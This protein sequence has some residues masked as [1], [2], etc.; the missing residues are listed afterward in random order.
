MEQTKLPLT[1]RGEWWTCKF[2]GTVSNDGS[3]CY[4][5]GRSRVWA[6]RLGPDLIPSSDNI[7]NPRV[8][9]VAGLNGRKEIVRA[10]RFYR[11]RRWLTKYQR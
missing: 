11:L 10:P 2:D 8:H 4:W 6:E 1:E 9:V 3:F 7:F 5:C